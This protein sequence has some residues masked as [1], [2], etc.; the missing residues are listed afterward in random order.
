ML[1]SFHN[2]Y[3]ECNTNTGSISE[4]SFKRRLIK[5]PLIPRKKNL[6]VNLTKNE[7]QSCS[8]FTLYNIN[9]GVPA[10]YFSDFPSGVTKKMHTI[11][12]ILSTVTQPN[13]VLS[14]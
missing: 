8:V 11:I 2:L 6:T 5:S 1:S 12:F 14:F 13:I 9:A 7:H 10:R 4:R 3:Q